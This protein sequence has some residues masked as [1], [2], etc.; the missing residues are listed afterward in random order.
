[1]FFGTIREIRE[2]VGAMLRHLARAL[3]RLPVLRFVDDF[4]AADREESVEVA[5]KCFARD[6]YLQQVHLAGR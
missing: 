2:K 3:L 4:F 5:M 6:H 1:M